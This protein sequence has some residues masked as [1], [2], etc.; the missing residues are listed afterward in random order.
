MTDD[1]NCAFTLLHLLYAIVAACLLTVG[2][3]LG[4]AAIEASK[5]TKKGKRS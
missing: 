5:A 4:W 3:L 2:I 1:L